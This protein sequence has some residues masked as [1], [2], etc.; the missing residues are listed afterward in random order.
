MSKTPKGTINVNFHF[1]S[2]KVRRIKGK[3]KNNSFIRKEKE[4]FG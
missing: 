3:L 2:Y 4:K 1:F